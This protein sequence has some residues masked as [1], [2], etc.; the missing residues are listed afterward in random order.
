MIG[1]DAVNLQRRQRFAPLANAD[2]QAGIAYALNQSAKV[3]LNY[4]VDGYWNSLRGFN[5]AGSPINLNRFY[6]GPTLKLT[7]A[8]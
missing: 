7:V 6:Q 5:S 4:R 1:D 2:A 3:S 8:Y